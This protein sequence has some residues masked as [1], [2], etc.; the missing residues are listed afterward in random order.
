MC[1]LSMNWYRKRWKPK[2]Y[3]LMILEILD[4]QISYGVCDFLMDM[5]DS[6]V[7]NIKLLWI[8]GDIDMKL[9]C[10]FEIW[11]DFYGSY[12]NL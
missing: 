2:I 10:I 5:C 7:I 4:V 1:F 3:E 6:T 12:Q 11:L 8:W 9:V